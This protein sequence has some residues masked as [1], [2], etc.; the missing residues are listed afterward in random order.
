MVLT[1]K[2]YKLK[3]FILFNFLNWFHIL[4]VQKNGL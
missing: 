2:K 4:E 3:M 1:L